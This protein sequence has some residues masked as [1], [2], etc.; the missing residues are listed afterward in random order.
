MQTIIVAQEPLGDFLILALYHKQ[1]IVIAS[2]P[3]R[4]LADQIATST[5]RT[6]KSAEP[7]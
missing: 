1:W 3:S 7:V 6:L 2:S 5:Q 4:L